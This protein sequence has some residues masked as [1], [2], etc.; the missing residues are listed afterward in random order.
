MHSVI[1]HMRVSSP[2]TPRGTTSKAT[3]GRSPSSGSLARLGRCDS[4]S[5]FHAVKKAAQIANEV[6]RCPALLSREAGG[7]PLDQQTSYHFC[8]GCTAGEAV[9]EQEFVSETGE[10]HRG[11]C[12]CLAPLF[13]PYG[14]LP[15]ASK[16]RIRLYAKSRIAS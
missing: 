10:R 7:D 13:G 15:P 9:E 12:Y 3:F 14:Q 2:S 16:N 8:H 1:N 11:P 4:A 6:R 5:T